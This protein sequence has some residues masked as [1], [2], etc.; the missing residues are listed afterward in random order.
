LLPVVD[1]SIRLIVR[2]N[3][4]IEGICTLF[5]P[6]KKHRYFYRGEKHFKMISALKKESE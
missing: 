3:Y 2:K 1:D 6:D 5:N 4:V